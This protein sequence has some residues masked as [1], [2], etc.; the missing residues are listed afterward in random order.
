MRANRTKALDRDIGISGKGSFSRVL[1]GCKGFQ[2]IPRRAAWPRRPRS[3]AS[4]PAGSRPCA[5]RRFY[6]FSAL[7]SEKHASSSLFAGGK[8]KKVVA[9]VRLPAS[10]VRSYLGAVPER[11]L[12]LWH[13]N[14]MAQFHAGAT[15]CN[16]YLAN[17]LAALFIA[18]GQDVANIANSAVG[19]LRPAPTRPTAATGRSECRSWNRRK[20]GP[21]RLS[22]PAVA[23]RAPACWTRR[24]TKGGSVV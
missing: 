7:D 23:R 22:G 11:I 3:S 16:A 10:V 13:V 14:V 20:E 19:L 17:G 18:C 6:L 24:W 9:G 4:C 5:P 21:D 2:W 8:G 15:T 1:S 12:E